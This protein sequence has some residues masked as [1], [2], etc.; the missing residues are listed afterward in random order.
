MVLVDYALMATSM[1]IVASEEQKTHS[2]VKTSP[3]KC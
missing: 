3:L 2:Q 1:E